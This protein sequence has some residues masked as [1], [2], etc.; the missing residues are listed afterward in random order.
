MSLS[1]NIAVDLGIFVCV[2]VA[3]GHLLGLSAHQ[4][5][6]AA[7]SRKRLKTMRSTLEI[8]SSELAALRQILHNARREAAAHR[9]LLSEERRDQLSLAFFMAERPSDSD[10]PELEEQLRE[11]A[12][13]PRFDA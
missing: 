7:K 2:L 1:G 13:R 12:S 8:K 11:A 10:H 4:L 9:E 6:R 3:S 5:G